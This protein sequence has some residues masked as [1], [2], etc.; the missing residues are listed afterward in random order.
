MIFLYFALSLIGVAAL[1]WI[2]NNRIS[3]PENFRTI[4]NV[5][6]GLILVGMCLWL[7]NTYVPM[8]KSIKTILN[9]VVVVATCVGV[10]QAVGL[11]DRV[12]RFWDNMIH[13]RLSEKEPSKT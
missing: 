13:H 2:V 9:I 10:L 6:L 1:F 4:V 7:I 8:A 3:M 5:V 11:W 12:V